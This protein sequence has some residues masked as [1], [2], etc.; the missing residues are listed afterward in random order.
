MKEQPPALNRNL[1]PLDLNSF[2]LPPRGGAVAGPAEGPGHLSWSEGAVRHQHRA[3]RDGTALA[4][5]WH[6]V[7]TALALAPCVFPAARL[8]T[9]AELPVGN[10]RRHNQ[11]KNPCTSGPRSQ[12]TFVS[13]LIREQRFFISNEPQIW[14]T[15]ESWGRKLIGKYRQNLA[16]SLNEKKNKQTHNPSKNSCNQSTLFQ[17]ALK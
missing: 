14:C 13:S 9:A 4:R 8:R 2:P 12:G 3:Q 5:R 11:Q 15:T 17:P 7:G 10:G 16:I 1:A 6:G